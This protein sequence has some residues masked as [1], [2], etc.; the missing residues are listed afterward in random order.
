MSYD[1]KYSNSEHSWYI[2]TCV[3]FVSW[4]LSCHN[5]LHKYLFPSWESC[6]NS[7][8]CEPLC[9]S[10]EHHTDI[11]IFAAAGGY[12]HFVWR[13]GEM[14]QVERI[15]THPASSQSACAPCW[16]E[17]HT[18]PAPHRSV[19]HQ[20]HF[21]NSPFHLPGLKTPQTTIWHQPQLLHCVGNERRNTISTQNF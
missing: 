21:F 6:T 3:I 9:I 11:L 16:T 5:I 15:Q 4:C 14:Q 1:F 8:T 17:P 18:A 19:S 2:P 10:S 20:P 12:F 7:C 13:C